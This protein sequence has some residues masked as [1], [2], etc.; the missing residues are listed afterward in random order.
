MPA[1]RFG[2]ARSF[3][4]VRNVPNWKDVNPRLGASYDLFGNGKTALKVSLGRYVEVTATTV[5]AANNPIT[6]SVNSVTRTWND[7][8]FPE[9]DSRRGNFV[10]DCDL[11][12]PTLNA[13]CGAIDNLNFGKP[14]V[15]T[16]YTDDVLSGFG[17]RNSSWDFVTEVQHQLLPRISLTGGYYRNRAAHFRV[18]DNLLVTPED[19]TQYCIAAPRDPRLPGGGGQQVC[20]LYDI[21]PSKFGQASSIETQA[22][23]YTGASSTVNC[24]TSGSLASTGG[25]AGGAGGFC[26]SSDFFAAGFNARIGAGTQFGGGVDTGRTLID[27]CLLID[28]PQQLL[29]SDPKIRSVRRRKSSCSRVIGYPPISR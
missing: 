16:R 7:L 18:T 4:A 8:L 20:G 25:S 27:N 10:P 29:N 11:N 23:H 3:E 12:N 24:A 1:G 13:E 2:P 19:Y 22:S 15:T 26:G 28:S 17:T 14:N 21:N 5:P 9:G 6:T